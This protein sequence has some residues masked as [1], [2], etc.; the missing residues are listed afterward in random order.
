T[1]GGG[2]RMDVD[3]MGFVENGDEGGDEAAKKKERNTSRLNATVAI[4]VA[5]LATFAGIAKVKDDNIVQAM[6]QAQ[7]KSIDTWAWYQAKKIRLQSA[8][9]ALDQFE[10]MEAMAPPTA[11]PLL[12]KKITDYKKQVE[13]QTTELSDVEKQAKEFDKDYD[14]LNIHDD[15]FDLCDAL[16]ALS[17]SLFA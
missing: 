15:Q 3:P 13:K 12:D 1:N 10:V 17:I 4:A 16:L 14:R 9:Q 2:K 6:Q 11:H 7:A 5:L 8:N